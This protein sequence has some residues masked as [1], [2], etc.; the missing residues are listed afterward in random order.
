MTWA[1]AT[2][3]KPAQALP[4]APSTS[5]LAYERTQWDGLH[6][7]RSFEITGAN[8]TQTRRSDTDAAVLAGNTAPWLF[9]RTE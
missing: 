9:S 8:N 6:A 3:A 2:P 1:W 5:P 4:P 7:R